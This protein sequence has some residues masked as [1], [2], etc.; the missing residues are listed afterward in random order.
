MEKLEERLSRAIED[1]PSVPVEKLKYAEVQKMEEHDDITRQESERKAR[2]MWTRYAL[3]AASICLCLLVVF[4]L[5][6]RNQASSIVDFDVNPSIE[7]VLD[8][9][10]KVIR[11]DAIND[12]GEEV[13]EDIDYKNREVDQ[14]VYQ[15]LDAMIAQGYLSKEKLENHILLSV[16]HPDHEQAEELRIRLNS[17]VSK[18]LEEKGIEAQVTDQ[19]MVEDDEEEEIAEEYGISLGKLTLIRKVMKEHKNLKIDDLADLSLQE[20]TQLLDDSREAAETEQ[21]TEASSAS[22]PQ[23]TA[24]APAATAQPSTRAPAYDDDDDDDSDD[25][26]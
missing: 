17:A 2:P 9:E 13:L 8:K 5:P 22:Q 23:T 4:R 26:D 1:A 12:E 15:M 3:A 6:F 7:I 14:V 19:E 24:R 18:Y 25:D 10:N 20:L 21:T 11:M 16:E